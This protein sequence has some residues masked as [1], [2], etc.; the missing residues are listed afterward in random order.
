MLLFGPNREIQNEQLFL[1]KK[2]GFVASNGLIEY[3][4]QLWLLAGQ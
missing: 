3:E 2:L 4:S 1:D